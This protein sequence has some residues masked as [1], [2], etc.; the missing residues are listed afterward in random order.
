MW[1]EN[2]NKTAACLAVRARRVH[3]APTRNTNTT[4]PPPFLSARARRVRS[5]APRSRRRRSEGRGTR[6]RCCRLDSSRRYQPSIPQT[7]RA[8]IASPLPYPASISPACA[9]TV[10]RVQLDPASRCPR[11]RHRASIPRPSP[12]GARSS[13]CARLRPQRPQPR[14]PSPLPKSPSLQ[15]TA[16]CASRPGCGCSGPCRRTTG[17]GW[18]LCRMCLHA[19]GGTWSRRMRFYCGCAGGRMPRPRRR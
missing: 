13:H 7:T 11:V 12:A 3:A 6:T 9:W 2:E 17:S 14:C 5:P 10:A 8:G 19:R 18:R 15:T 4:F 16:T 1:S